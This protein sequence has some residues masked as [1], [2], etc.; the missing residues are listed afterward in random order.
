MN[1]L[2]LPSAFGRYRTGLD[3]ALRG[4]LRQGEPPLL[5]RMMRY[6]LGWEDADGVVAANDGG[7]A[8]RP[9]LLLLACESVGGDWRQAAPAAAALEMVHNF[10]LVHDDIQDQD[11]ER[12]HR[13]TVWALWGQAQ[14]INAGDG[15][16][17]LAHL[18]AYRL[19]EAGVPPARVLQVVRIMDERTMEMVEGQSMDLSF[20][21]QQNVSLREYLDMVSRKTGALLDAALSIGAV[22]GGSDERTVQAF[23]NCG[24]LLGLAF[25]VRDDML[26]VWG[27][28]S[29]TGKPAGADIRRRKKSLP[30]IYALSAKGEER[31]RVAEIMAQPEITEA[32]IG[33]VMLALDALGASEYCHSLARSKKSEALTQ[34][35]QAGL[36]P[37]TYAELKEVADF[38]LERNY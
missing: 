6:H 27:S 5:Y 29:E 38:V 2:Q 28:E 8:L 18:A 23:G 31:D 21:Q 16:L 3:A 30:L 36:A 13:P 26:G 7:K 24:R 22:V 17:A 37:E 1:I 33:E 20:E 9:T 15:L 4:I 14:A 32:D 10:S 12:R 34:L 11:M 25:Q 35:T 19:E